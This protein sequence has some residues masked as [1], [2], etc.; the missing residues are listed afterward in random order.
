MKLLAVSQLE[1]HSFQ[2]PT[3]LLDSQCVNTLLLEVIISS[4]NDLVY[5]CDLN[6]RTLQIISDAW[7]AS[8]N[9]DSKCPIVWNDSRHA[10]SCR[11]YV[12]CT[13]EE[14]GSHG[15]VCIIWHQ[16]LHHPS[17]HGTSQMGK[18]L[19]VKAHIAKLNK[20][21]QSEVSE[22][23]STT[24]DET[25][26]AILKRQGTWGITIVSSQKKFIFDN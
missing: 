6:D 10:L 16:V 7:W 21:T 3:T 11:F 8:M 4:E 25:A 1:L 13:I 5:I 23:T 12:H 26:L 17:G 18:H 9:F 2:I 15:I 24:V 20:L 22:L 19:F 14:T